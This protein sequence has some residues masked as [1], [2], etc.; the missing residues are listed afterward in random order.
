MAT[1]W[2]VVHAHYK[3]EPPERSD[4][5]A[6]FDEEYKAYR[7]PK[8]RKFVAGIEAGR[9]RRLYVLRKDVAVNIR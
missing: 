1:E 5:K 9:P 3:G 6:S 8:C 7:C 2:I 4:F